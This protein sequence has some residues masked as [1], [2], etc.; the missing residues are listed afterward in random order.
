MAGWH[1][2]HMD[3]NL[4]KPHKIMK[5]REARGAAIHVIANSWTQLSK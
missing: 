5:D 3:M 1:H 4:N 2:R